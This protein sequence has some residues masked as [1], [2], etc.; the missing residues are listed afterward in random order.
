MSNLIG[1]VNGQKI[2]EKKSTWD[3][4]AWTDKFFT[5]ILIALGIINIAVGNVAAGIIIGSIP[6]YIWLINF[7]RSRA[8]YY[9]QYHDASLGHKS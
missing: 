3:T 5:V 6:A 1:T 7:E 4:Y 8:D 9:K 2:Y